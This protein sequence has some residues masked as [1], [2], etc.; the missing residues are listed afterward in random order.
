MIFYKDIAV[1]P[2]VYFD[3][4]SN[5]KRL[6]SASADLDKGSSAPAVR[7]FATNWSSPEFEEFVDAL[8]KLVDGLNIEQ[9]SDE[10]ERAGEVWKRVVE[11]EVG[12]WP[13]DGEESSMKR[14][15]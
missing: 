13:E 9:G 1:S 2:Q 8:G 11:L 3:A 12:F 14:S 15:H 6:L 10:W 4:W 7:K 5:V